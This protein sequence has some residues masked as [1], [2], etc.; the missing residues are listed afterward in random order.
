MERLNFSFSTMICYSDI[1]NISFKVSSNLVFLKSATEGLNPY[2]DMIT[3]E[4][5]LRK[6]V[7][8]I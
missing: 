3:L 5:G 8:C 7:L 1:I 2:L 6:S 4:R